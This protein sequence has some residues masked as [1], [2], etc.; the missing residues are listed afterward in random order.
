MKDNVAYRNL[1]Q[2]GVLGQPRSAP[3]NLGGSVWTVGADS[4]LARYYS[5][6][7]LR[8]SRDCLCRE[9]YQKGL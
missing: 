5:T 1:G 4:P 8:E 3:T 9:D 7:A 2:I 6:R